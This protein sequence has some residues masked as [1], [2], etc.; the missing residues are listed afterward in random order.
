MTPSQAFIIE[1][2]LIHSLVSFG[3]VKPL[4]ARILLLQGVLAFPAIG[5]DLGSSRV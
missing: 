5:R 1:R 3:M 2:Y 4:T